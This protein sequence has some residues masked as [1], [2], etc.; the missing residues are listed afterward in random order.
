MDDIQKINTNTGINSLVNNGNQT[1]VENQ[2]N[3]IIVNDPNR[4]TITINTADILNQQNR[5]QIIQLLRRVRCDYVDNK[6]IIYKVH[7]D[8]LLDLLEK[9][10][11]SNEQVSIID[12]EIEKEKCQKIEILITLVNKDVLRVDNENSVIIIFKILY[13]I[14]NNTDLPK[15]FVFNDESIIVKKFLENDIAHIKSY[16]AELINEQINQWD[17][18]NTD[19]EEDE[20]PFGRTKEQHNTLKNKFIYSITN[21]PYD[22]EKI[23]DAIKSFRQSFHKFDEWTSLPFKLTFQLYKKVNGKEVKFSIFNSE[24]EALGNVNTLKYDYLFNKNDDKNIL[25]IL[26]SR[27]I[28]VALVNK[29]KIKDYYNLFNIK[30]LRATIEY[31]EQQVALRDLCSIDNLNK[32]YYPESSWVDKM[33][34]EYNAI[35]LFEYSV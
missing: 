8:L 14:C 4:Q 2:Y 1:Q 30:G 17:I 6:E 19:I 5:E 28:N 11:F 32:S 34:K 3:T 24:L 13:D 7:T 12:M 21:D 25:H 33:S 23:E 10:K 26:Y 18:E 29:I 27:L 22:F 35:N 15:T 16:R 9:A 20:V 31:D